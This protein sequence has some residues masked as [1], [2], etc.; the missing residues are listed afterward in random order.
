MSYE[1]IYIFFDTNSLENYY[2]R[3]VTKANGKSFLSLSKFKFPDYYYSI[4]NFIQDNG[5]QDKVEIL[6]PEIVWMEL[7]KHMLQQYE[8]DKQ[9]LIKQIQE[10]RNI[11]SDLID[12]S[13]E[14]KENNYPKYLSIL[15]N[16]LKENPRTS[17]QI[18]PC[19]K[20]DKCISKIIKNAMYTEPP[21][22]KAHKNTKEYSD[23]GLKDALIAET[24]LINQQ[25]NILSIF[26][27]NDN[28]FKT[29]FHDFT[30]ITVCDEIDDRKRFEK[31]KELISEQ[32]L[33]KEEVIKKE[34]STNDY[35]LQ[36]LIAQTCLDI[37]FDYKFNNFE[38]INE[39]TDKD[40]TE[41]S[42]IWDVIF[43]MY[44]GEKLYKFHVVYD[45]NAH[46]LET[47]EIIDD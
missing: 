5:L 28:D 42:N 36:E 47:G 37:N 27:S 14:F 38:S 44:V 17:A 29:V 21:F 16:E 34:I 2:P 8:I 20:D 3:D 43:T 10:Y 11:F 24:V 23:A 26:V 25:E 33:Q 46:G 6:I 15:M 19:P 1:K 22:A 9:N 30:N 32:F 13:C 31:I 40:D 39:Q 35:L 18:K 4:V 41:A 7:E 45:G 12:I